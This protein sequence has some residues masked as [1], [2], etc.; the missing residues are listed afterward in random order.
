[1]WHLNSQL[2]HVGI[3]F[4]D[5]GSNLALLHWDLG[6]LAAGQPGKTQKT[7]SDLVER[8]WSLRF[9]LPLMLPVV[10]HSAALRTATG[11][12]AKVR[13][14]EMNFH[15]EPVGGDARLL[16]MVTVQKK[17]ASYCL[18]KTARKDLGGRVCL[19]NS[20][21]EKKPMSSFQWHALN[22]V[23]SLRISPADSQLN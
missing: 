9:C 22:S 19:C 3:W 2:R 17:E 18:I 5:Q 8:G 10:F 11:S 13:S 1:M 14:S 12:Q 23:L 15:G 7:R 20:E 16:E 21:R 4:P 6:V